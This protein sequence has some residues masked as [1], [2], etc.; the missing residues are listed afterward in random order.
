MVTCSGRNSSLLCTDPRRRNPLSTGITR[1]INDVADAG[2]VSH[3][4]RS[5]QSFFLVCNA[6]PKP[7]PAPPPSPSPPPTRNP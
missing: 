7:A 2:F 3:N 1:S 6:S 4:Q 5:V